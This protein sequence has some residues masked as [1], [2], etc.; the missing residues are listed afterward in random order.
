MYLAARYSQSGRCDPSIETIAE[1]TGIYR[2]TVIDALAELK[3][4]GVLSAKRRR[5][6]S[7][8][9]PYRGNRSAR[10]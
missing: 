1:G 10:L 9:W 2:E 8:C 7:Y 6:T 3:R 5:R 4:L